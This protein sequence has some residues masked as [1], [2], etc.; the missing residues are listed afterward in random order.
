MRY[1][2]FCI[3]FTLFYLLF[4]QSKTQKYLF[5]QTCILSCYLERYLVLL[6]QYLIQELLD[7][8]LPAPCGIDIF[9]LKLATNDLCT[10][11]H[12]R[13]TEIQ[14]GDGTTGIENVEQ[15]MVV[16]EKKCI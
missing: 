12:Q 9:I 6:L 5:Y 16:I 13:P 14:S 8:S 3:Q 7:F 11:N 10:C 2:F 15:T 1:L 4:T